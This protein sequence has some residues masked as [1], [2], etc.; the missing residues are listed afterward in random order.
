MPAKRVNRDPRGEGIYPRSA[1]QQSRSP[2]FNLPGISL[3]KA[4]GLLSSPAGI[5][6]LA[7]K[8]PQGLGN[9]QRNAAIASTDSRISAGPL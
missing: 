5:N 7:T 4:L 3:C 1:A 8:A 6:P 9:P 2:N